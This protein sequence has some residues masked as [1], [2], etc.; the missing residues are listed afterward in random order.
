[1]A[2]FH[3]E[4]RTSER[5][6]PAVEA[7]FV[8]LRTNTSKYDHWKPFYYG[9]RH[10]FKSQLI[11]PLEALAY[12]SWGIAQTKEVPSESMTE[13]DHRQNF[14]DAFYFFIAMRPYA[15]AGLG[16]GVS[17]RFGIT[18]RVSLSLNPHLGGC[19]AKKQ[20]PI[21]N[22]TSSRLSKRGGLTT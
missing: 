16:V 10:V 8:N 5:S 17:L 12:F 22:V 14:T 2:E 4:K 19:A 13:D 7:G 20:I 6:V 18:V 9:Y 1:M 11:G 3:I 15:G 21:S